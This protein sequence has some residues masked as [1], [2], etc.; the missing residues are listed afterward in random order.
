MRQGYQ[1][2]LLF[3]SITVHNKN[4]SRQCNLPA[5]IEQVQDKYYYHAI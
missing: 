5:Q 2:K 3:R 4:V 1:K